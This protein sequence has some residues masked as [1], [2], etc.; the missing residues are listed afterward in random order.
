[1]GEQLSLLLD[2]E[3]THN[4]S[5]TWDDVQKGRAE[6]YQVLEPCDKCKGYPFN[7]G[8]YWDGFKCWHTAANYAYPK[9]QGNGY[10][11]RGYLRLV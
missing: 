10:C 4:G 6:Y 1:M 3:Q 2:L 5:P 7:L 9:N 8:G 11:K